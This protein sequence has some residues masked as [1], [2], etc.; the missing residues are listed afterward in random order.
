MEFQALHFC[1][2]C[3]SDLMNRLLR[4]SRLKLSFFNFFLK[5]DVS[6][7]QTEKVISFQRL[8]QILGSLALWKPI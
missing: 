6:D 8:N 3:P 7:W 2:L 4:K 5:R 1:L